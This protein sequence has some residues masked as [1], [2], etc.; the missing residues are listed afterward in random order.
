LR[1]ALAEA[2]VEYEDRQDPAVDVGLNSSKRKKSRQRSACAAAG[3]NGLDRHLD[4]HAL[5]AAGNQALNVHPD[6]DYALV[7]TERGLLII[8]DAMLAPATCRTRPRRNSIRS[9]CP[10]A[11]EIR[12][13][14]VEGDRQGQGPGAGR[15]PL[16]APVLRPHLAGLSRRLRDAGYRHRHRAL[17]TGLRRGG[18]RLLPPLRHE[19][20]RNPDPGAG[21]REVRGFAAAVRRHADLDA[22]GKIVRLLRES[23][24]LFAVDW[25]YSHSYMHCWRHKTPVILRATIQ[26][27]ASMDKKVE[28]ESLREAALRGIEATKFY[29]DWGKARLHG[30]I[31]NRPDWTLSR[32]RQ[33][34]VP[35]PFFVH[36]ETGA[37][38]PRT[39]ELMEEVGEAR[40]K[41]RHRDLADHPPEELLGA[42][43]RITKR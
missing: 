28:G 13:Q 15:D 22:N 32:A 9:R 10:A 24:A 2:E 43:R 38:H 6:F 5:D 20:R 7:E 1:S 11:G 39:L 18:L 12:H 30:M 27:F 33:W 21:R 36:K 35:M 37:L 17:G 25:K 14:G 8:A 29:P 23:G 26:W 41:G 16:Q 4:H 34:G 40:R 31:A 3:Q 42:T 19:G